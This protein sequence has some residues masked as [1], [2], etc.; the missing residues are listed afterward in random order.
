MENIPLPRAAK[1]Y[2]RRHELGSE[3]AKRMAEK[4]G[5]TNIKTYK[6]NKIIGNGSFGVVF[7]AD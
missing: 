4:N 7:K 5:R 1:D 3:M 6:P 2:V